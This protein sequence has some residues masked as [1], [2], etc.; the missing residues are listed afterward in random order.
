[1]AQL[2][3]EQLRGKTLGRHIEY[4]DG[5]KDGIFEGGQYAVVGHAAVDGSSTDAPTAQVLHLVLHQGNERRD[6]NADTL[7]CQCRHLESDALAATSRHEAQRVVASPYTLDDFT[8]DAP[9]VIVA[10]VLL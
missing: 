3:A 9:K 1:M 7:L 8:L 5:S 2:G 6:D 10:P 4:L